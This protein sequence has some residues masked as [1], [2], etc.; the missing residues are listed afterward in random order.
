M[1]S[2]EL[3][4]FIN[5]THEH[6]ERP[7]IYSLGDSWFQLPFMPIDLQKQLKLIFFR[8]CLFVN[9]S[10][11]G[12]ATAEI[13]RQFSDLSAHLGELEIDILIVS[14]GGNDIAGKEL[15]E[16]LKKPDEPQRMGSFRGTSL[17]PVV[18]K[19]VR[20][21]TFSNAMDVLQEDFQ[22]IVDIRNKFRRQCHIV[23]H[24]YGY[25]I[26]NGKRA[27]RLGGIFKKGP[28]LKPH[29]DAAGVGTLADRTTLMRWLVDEFHAR[30]QRLA[31]RNQRVHLVDSRDALNPTQWDDEIHPTK[32]GFKTIAN[33]HWEPKLRSVIAQL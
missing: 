23:L 11:P 26:P 24:S 12:R 31:E 3:Q 14:M 19:H 27:E 8:E 25:V 7:R 4:R 1:N 15:A 32:S 2:Q 9:N 21:A 13:K 17:P 30:L 29:L 5:A 16:Y 28:W 6:P 10:I 18:E 33:D 22:R 20:L